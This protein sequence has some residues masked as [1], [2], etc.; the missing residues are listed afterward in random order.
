MAVVDAKEVF[1]RAL[2]VLR[3]PKA[4]TCAD[5]ADE[6]FYLPSESSNTS[7]RWKTTKVQKAILN[8][9]G[10]DAI[11]K[12]DFFKPTRFGGTKMD[13][14]AMFYF[15]AHKK[16]NICFFQPT[17]ADSDEFVKSEIQPSIRDC[18]IVYDNLLDHSDKSSKNTLSYKAFHGC[19]TFYK[20]GHSPTSYERMT[21][22]CVILDELDQFNANV[23][24]KGNP[25]TL[26]WGR[27]R[28]SLFKK[29]IQTSKP[30]VS[31][32]SLIEK[33]SKA[34]MDMLEYYAQC[35]ECGGFTPIVWGGKD[36]PYGFKWQGRDPKTVVHMCKLCGVGW[37][38]DKLHSALETGFWQ[39]E[40]GYKT[41]DGILWLKDGQKCEPPRHIA[42]KTWS[43]YSTLL[44]W[45]QIVEEWY[46][47]LGDWQK[48]Q[49]FTNNVLAEPWDINY[50]GSLTEETIN[51]IIPIDDISNV[52]AITA[53]ID[54]QDDRLEVQYVGHDLKGNC[55]ILDYSI[56]LG[57]MEDGS[58]YL[59]MGNEVMTAR[60]M[61]GN[62][63]MR[64]LKACIDTQGHHTEMV[65]KFLIANR[66]KNL[67]IGINGTASGTF[68]IADKASTYKNVSGSVYYSIGVNN[69]KAKI[70]SMIRNANEDKNAFRIYT[71][72]QL[73]PDYAKQLTSEK[74]EVKRQNGLDKIIFTNTG[75]ARNE[76][77]DTL[78]YALAAKAYIQ[79]HR[80]RQGRSLFTA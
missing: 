72:A 12:V 22:D 43:G 56:F 78:V 59:E 44:T 54:T 52:V 49:S 55:Y 17:K 33:S 50:G 64:V 34:A 2:S 48:L 10:N 57:D 60:F 23:G 4:T 73:P 39:G 26:S 71:G 13:I 35:P 5:W 14:A 70:F 19:N 32:F 36:V 40:G 51:G 46:D 58:V 9:F 31:G 25:T 3:V 37:G 76:A 65:H 30:T 20:G 29:Q 42:F 53:G 1:A 18:K 6:N 67:F 61:V 62:K 69:I 38:N 47:A 11:E 63:K 15:I 75:K 16:R 45:Q 28:N 68:E 24:G 79:K 27:I 21:L 8:S 77:L 74:M 80:G 41:Y 7:G 66:K